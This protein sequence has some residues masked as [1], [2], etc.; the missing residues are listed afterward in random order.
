L[1]SAVQT[2]GDR[3]A[4]LESLL[5]EFLLEHLGLCERAMSSGGVLTIGSNHSWTT[6]DPDGHALQV[7]LLRSTLVSR[8][9][10]Q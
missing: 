2:L 1:K 8:P 5:R 6:L 7:R 4:S 10:G 9:S 3:R